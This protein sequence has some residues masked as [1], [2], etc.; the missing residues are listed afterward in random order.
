MRAHDFIDK[1]E[2]RDSQLSRDIRPGKCVLVFAG[3]F[4][5]EIS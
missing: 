1:T 4:V 2:D 3:Q 5:K